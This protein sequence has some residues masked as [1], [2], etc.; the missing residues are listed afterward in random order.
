MS[1][2]TTYL[3]L[4]PPCGSHW[5]L[6]WGIELVTEGKE[7]RTFKSGEKLQEAD[8]QRGPVSRGTSSDQQQDPPDP[9]CFSGHIWIGLARYFLKYLYVWPKEGGAHQSFVIHTLGQYGQILRDELYQRHRHL[10]GNKGGWF[11]STQPFELCSSKHASTRR[12]PLSL[13]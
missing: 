7:Q 1:S 2:S 12:V 4:C 9:K 11:L 5:R 3:W 8:Q 13:G 10:G 6:D